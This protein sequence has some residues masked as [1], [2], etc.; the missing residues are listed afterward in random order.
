M[1]EK[2]DPLPDPAT[3]AT[4]YYRPLLTVALAVLRNTN[5]AKDAVQSFVARGRLYV[6]LDSYDPQQSENFL[7][8]LRRC[9]SRFC[10]DEWDKLNTIRKHEKSWPIMTT[11]G[12]DEFEREFPSEAPSPEENTSR[13]E[14]KAAL[15]DCVRRLSQ[16]RQI[17]IRLSLE[18]EMSYKEIAVKTGYVE[19]H[20]K[21]EM[22]RIRRVLKEC[23]YEKGFH[24]GH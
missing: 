11:K 4:T 23:L 2:T 5:D 1:T 7:S 16:A 8:Y 22:P 9:F 24:H 17:I 3:V 12:G 19:G 13:S 20:I 6:V 10:V 14:L 18:E 15:S 21:N